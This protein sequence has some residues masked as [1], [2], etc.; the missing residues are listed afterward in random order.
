MSKIPDFVHREIFS[1]DWAK[2]ETNLY[3]WM[4][5]GKKYNI[6][7]HKKI[8][9]VHRF[10]SYG[11]KGWFWKWLH[12]TTPKLYKQKSWQKR[13]TLMLYR[14]NVAQSGANWLKLAKTGSQAYEFVR[15]FNAFYVVSLRGS[16]VAFCSWN[17]EVLSSNPTWRVIFFSF[18]GSWVQSP[19]NFISFF[20]TWNWTFFVIYDF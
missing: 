18:M 3:N 15:F 9:F 11:P 14:W 8:C 19:F 4:K 1:G 6:W 10:K 7:R 16:V 13:Y 17:Q 5:Y 12:P 20:S 2:I